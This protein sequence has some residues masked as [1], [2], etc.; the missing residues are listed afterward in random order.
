VDILESIPELL[1]PAGG[2]DSA[3]ASIEGG[4]DALY[5]GFSE[6]S[7]RRQARNFDRL[8][9]RRLHRF[10]R[11]KGVRLYVTLNTILLDGEIEA[12]S[13]LLAFLGRFP[14]DAVLVQDWGLASLIRERHPGIVIHAS[15]QAAVQGVSAARIAKEL[16]ATRIVLPRETSLS[17]MARLHAEEPGLEYEAFVHGAL[18]YSF[19]GLCLAS[20]IVLG[21]SGNRGECAQ[22]CR[23]YYEMD[24]AEVPGPRVSDAAKGGRGY[25]FSCRDLELGDRVRELAAAGICSLK[26]EGRMKGPEYCYAVAQY[27]RGILDVM[28]GAGP[29]GD[30][31]RSR[32][33]AARIA[34]SRSP[35]EGWLRERGG[36]SLIDSEYPGHRGLPAGVLRS[37]SSSRLTLDLRSDLCLRDGLLAFEDGD[38]FK[39]VRFAATGLR[40][41]R[42]GR[43][44]IRA[45]AG[46]TIEIDL[47][48]VEER[49]ARLG[50]GAH[51]FRISA[52]DMDRRAPSPEEYEPE[53]EDLELRMRFEGRRLAAEIESPNFSAEALN[54]GSTGG[55]IP[56]EAGEELP[57]DRA[58]TAGGF[59]RALEVF[60]ES[61]EANFRLLARADK[62]ASIELSSDS[63]GLPRSCAIEDLFMPP[64]ILKREKNR[65]YAR[66]AEIVAEAE[67]EY[68]RG[69]A[70]TILP[71]EPASWPAAVPRAAVFAPPRAK[72][73]FPRPDL[74]SGMPFA[75]R[76]DLAEGRTLPSWEGRLWLPLAPL[77]AD[78]D[79]YGKLALTRVESEIASG[80]TVMVGIGA[81]HHIALAREMLRIVTPTGKGRIGTLR[82]FL[83]FNLYVAN[84]FAY[85]K[86]SSLLP[87]IEFAYRYLEAP[88]DGASAMAADSRLV[89]VGVGF[90]PPLFQSLGCALKHHV[91][92]GSC[93]PGCS[94]AWSAAIGDRDR[95]YAISVEG[96]V[97]MMFR[98]EGAGEK[99][100]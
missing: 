28:K 89:S 41:P 51:L 44:L 62:E 54:P 30:E 64:S 75:T 81:L 93:P 82:F 21:R 91:G 2:F 34:F 46:S 59:A 95:R 6:F 55:F 3:L 42:T 33:E 60:S 29:N 79:E 36:D 25:W 12:V 32:R 15:T 13:G 11:G 4:A 26:V 16:G 10:A 40:D 24:V 45:K 80:E 92:G 100:R 83:D 8:E 38:P 69:T 31:L 97:T 90:E 56:I 87:G 86:L 47:P 22:L 78:R 52:R 67:R 66:A 98:D 53:R 50:A 77:V 23:S 76:S 72:L 37:V 73:V 18:C 48:L 5:L 43:E 1:M 94:R 20:G 17:E 96:C 61:G 27:Y 35:T 7:A 70:A 68:A 19:S 58:R 65:I 63:E 85:A 9:Y 57:L 84:R 49:R 14:P 71:Q 39:P 99:R 74:P 88:P